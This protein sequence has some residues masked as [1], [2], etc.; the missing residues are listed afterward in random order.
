MNTVTARRWHGNGD[1]S[2]AIDAARAMMAPAAVVF[3][4]TPTKWSATSLRSAEIDDDVFELLVFDGGAQ[5]RWLR[6]GGTGR[7][8]LVTLDDRVVPD[9]PTL[10]TFAG[11]TDHH[12]LERRYLCWG[13]VVDSDSTS[14]TIAEPRLGVAGVELPA[15]GATAV[16]A[17][18]YLHCLELIG[19]V[20]H[21]NQRVV[22][23]VVVALQAAPKENESQ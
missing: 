13:T 12:V 5:L 21:G 18:M 3:V 14:L 4:S 8:A 9:S 11:A 6:Q 23:Q 15:E 20:A 22:E 19:A 10:A 17:E 2:E 7:A 16:G 1:A